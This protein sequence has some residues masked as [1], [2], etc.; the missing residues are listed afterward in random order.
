MLRR[1][2]ILITAVF[3]VFILRRPLGPKRW[4]ALIVL[5][6]GVTVVSLPSASSATSRSPIDSLLLHGMADHF[7]PRSKHE[8]GQA[9]SPDA[10]AAPAAHLARRSATYEGIA[11]DVP[12]PEPGMNYSLGLTCVLTAASAS[13]IAGVYFEKILRND[14]SASGGGGGVSLWIRNVQLGVYSVVAALIG[15][16]FWQDGAGI[17]EHGFFAGYNSVVWIAILLQSLGGL[18]GTLVIRDAGNIVKNFA[19][20]ISIIISFLVSV[21][22][23][24]FQVTATVRPPNTPLFWLLFS[25]P[26][27]CPGFADLSAQFLIGMF[28]VLLSTYLYNIADRGT[29]RP[30]PLHFASFEKPTIEGIFTP[31]SGTPRSHTPDGGSG[32]FNGDMLDAK[33]LRMTSSRPTSPVLTRQASRGNVRRDS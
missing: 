23:F 25:L 13:A 9:A 6:V 11:D 8:L 21:W 22:L 30:P 18:I 31:R 16:V 28:L 3:A 32:R 10:L 14:G 26:K 2:Q 12:P 24:K 15:G 20:S 1:L 27:P 29:H 19:T 4:F 5:T 7:F 17:R 33:G